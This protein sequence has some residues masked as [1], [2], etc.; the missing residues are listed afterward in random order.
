[1]QIEITDA[2]NNVVETYKQLQ[3]IVDSIVDKN[4]KDID[5]IIKKIKKSLSDLTNKELQDLILQLSIETY[6]FS[7]IKDMSILKQECAIALLKSAQANIFNGTSG[8]QVVR[9]NQAT[10]DTI[11][12]TVVN[13]LYNAVANNM[14]SKLDEAHRMVNVLSNV[15]ISK[16]AEA[17]L[18][19]VRDDDNRTSDFYDNS[20]SE[21]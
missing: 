7:H 9:N 19:G 16:N 5:N 17:K 18:K 20:N 12:K 10:V 14:K 21:N 8:T 2:K 15:L 11:D 6:Y 1:M 13:I 4:S 3:P